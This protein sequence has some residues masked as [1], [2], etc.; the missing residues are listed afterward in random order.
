MTGNRTI[1]LLDAQSK[2][3]RILDVEEATRTKESAGFS[4]AEIKTTT[5]INNGYRIY[6]QGD[7]EYIIS[8]KG[9]QHTKGADLFY[10]LQC[11]SVIFELKDVEIQRVY[12]KNWDEVFY[13]VNQDLEPRWT[14]DL[15]LLKKNP[16][17]EIFYENTTALDLIRNI[18]AL[19]DLEIY[20]SYKRENDKIT[21]RTI[22][23]KEPDKSP[24]RIITYDTNLNGITKTEDFKEAFT[25][26]KP[27]GKS[28][29]AIIEN[30]YRKAKEQN[31]NTPRPDYLDFD[32]VRLSL[33]GYEQ[34]G[35]ESYVENTKAKKR[36]G[37]GDMNKIK[38]VI[39][40][41]VE[42]QKTLYEKAK[43][44]LPNY[45][46]PKI[47]YNIT[48][49][50]INNTNSNLQGL[51]AGDYVIV[52]DL[53]M[54][55]SLNVKVLSISEDITNKNSVVDLDL[56]NFK[57]EYDSPA[58]RS[59]KRM[60]KTQERVERYKD[61]ET[62]NNIKT[63]ERI[64]NLENK[65]GESEVWR[66]PKILLHPDKVMA[67]KV[68]IAGLSTQDPM[69]RF[70]TNDGNKF[71]ANT[72][73]GELIVNG[74]SWSNSSYTGDLFVGADRKEVSPPAIKD[75]N[76]K[77]KY[78]GATV[79]NG[80]SVQDGLLA[81]SVEASKY[82]G[83]DFTG[84]NFTGSEFKSNNIENQK[85]IST[86]SIKAGGG[87]INRLDSSNIKVAVGP[88]GDAP[89][90]NTSLII[91]PSDNSMRQVGFYLYSSPDFSIT[92]EYFLTANFGVNTKE[93]KV[94]VTF[95]THKASAPQQSLNSKKIELMDL[96]VSS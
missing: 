48:A 53:E 12:G 24:Q 22:K 71:T 28:M 86:E 16:N 49:S 18:S 50:Y 15:S 61:T 39:Y 58:V 80:L 13:P 3:V 7:G 54:G 65:S 46:T 23:F 43:K 42:D 87:E 6:I 8:E 25:A 21:K 94:Y 81:D 60:D 88:Y 11:D 45:T 10:T 84:I 17:Q 41:E 68:T 52:Q 1:T 89:G 20:I 2:G 70:T 26:I 75:L 35:G 63:N 66:K 67:E 14:I 77:P 4:T 29:N 37:Y 19:L 93:G 59:A 96:K 56:G 5:N 27:Y 32:D 69:D 31:K 78:A 33:G 34:T 82:R 73:G 91:G 85:H 90:M 62:R 55:E 95:R 57:P 83:L 76:G 9:K 72:G 92:P 30:N 79:V 64:D 38:V 40:D 44:D 47:N 74:R 51:K 36:F